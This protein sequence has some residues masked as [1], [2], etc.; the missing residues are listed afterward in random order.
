MYEVVMKSKKTGRIWNGFYRTLK[1]ARKW[2]FE[3]MNAGFEGD[4]YQRF[5]E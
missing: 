2:Y 4:I 3:W 5:E 1:E